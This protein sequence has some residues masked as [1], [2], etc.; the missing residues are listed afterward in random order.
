MRDSES[1]ITLDEPLICWPWSEDWAVRTPLARR[2]AIWLRPL[3]PEGSKEALKSHPKALVLSV[4]ARILRL[5]L[6][7]SAM[8]IV[9][10]ADMNSKAF[11]ENFP[12]RSFG[13]SSLQPRP[14]SVK[15]PRPSSLASEKQRMSGSD[16]V[17]W[18]ILMPVCS[19]CL[20]RCCQ[21]WRS[22]ITGLRSDWW[23]YLLHFLSS[24]LSLFKKYLL[25]GMM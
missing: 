1:A 5:R 20:R 17:M 2:L 16:N 12:T 11:R 23:P 10:T 9:T 19:I 14:E 24:H 13:S 22:L 15:P 18:S 6:P 3:S 8:W 7:R 4:I 21:R 25:S